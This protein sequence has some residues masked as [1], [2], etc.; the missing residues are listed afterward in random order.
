MIGETRTVKIN[1]EHGI[2]A[3]IKSAKRG[4]SIKNYIEMLIEQD[5][6]VKE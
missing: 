5:C 1:K 2:V 3:K 4:L 6:E